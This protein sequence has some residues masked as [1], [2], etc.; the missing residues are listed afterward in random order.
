MLVF[1]EGV[2]KEYVIDPDRNIYEQ[3]LDDYGATMTPGTCQFHPRIIVT[4]F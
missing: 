4:L 3:F 1:V 2:E